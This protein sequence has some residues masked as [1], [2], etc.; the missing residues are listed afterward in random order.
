MSY[1]PV[2]RSSRSV[3]TAPPFQLRGDVS[4]SAPA[5]GSFSSLIVCGAPAVTAGDVRV[6]L[7]VVDIHIVDCH[8]YPGL[9]C[10]PSL[11]LLYIPAEVSMQYNQF[12]SYTNSIFLY[13]ITRLG[14][15][16]WPQTLILPL[17]LTHP[18]SSRAT[19]RPP[20]CA[21]SAPSRRL[22]SA[23][24]ERF[25]MTSAGGSALLCGGSS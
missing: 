6:Y 20:R 5:F 12:I 4:L 8:M 1:S 22:R 16:P 10:T 24:P 11:V 17:L 21:I 14:S 9:P 23:P 2:F 7:V 15:D 25:P 18:C 13:G 3:C 19:G